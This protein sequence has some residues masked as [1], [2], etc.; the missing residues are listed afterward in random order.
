[1]IV[2]YWLK[3][4]KF[5]HKGNCLASRG[6]PRDAE[7]LPK[8]RTFQFAP[9]NHYGFF[10]LH[11]LLSSGRLFNLHRRT[12]MDPFS[13]IL[14]LRQLHVDL[15]MLFYQFYAKITAYFDQEKFGMAPPICWRRTFGGKWR[16]DVKNDVKTSK[17][18]YWYQHFLASVGFTEIPV[19]YAR[20][21][22][23]V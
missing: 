18:S 12:I 21:I 1:M 11:T 23:L 19:G 14:F 17:S 3:I 5:C 8:R 4:W 16:Q 10:F 22:L 9:K 13:C 6:K 7:Q 2:R 20:N 15:N